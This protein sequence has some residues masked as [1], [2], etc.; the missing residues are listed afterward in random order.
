MRW[1]DV[2]LPGDPISDETISHSNYFAVRASSFGTA[3]VFATFGVV[4]WALRH[5]IRKFYPG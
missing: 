5:E 1:A 3:L 2:A 4:S